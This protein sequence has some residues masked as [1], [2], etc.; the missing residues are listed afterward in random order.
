MSPPAPASLP[1]LR[2][3]Q[4]AALD[5]IGEAFAAGHRRVTLTMPC[6]TGK[7]V[8]MAAL[9]TRLSHPQRVVVFVPTVRLLTQTAVALRAAVPD[10]RLHAVCSPLAAEF[11]VTAT[12][13]GV[14]DDDDIPVAAVA[15]ELGV[16]VTTD[17]DELADGL[18]S[19]GGH[20]V[21]ATYAS[22]AVVVAATQVAAAAWDLVICDEAHHTAGVRGKAWALPLDDAILPARR[23]LFATATV[24]VVDPPVDTEDPNAGPVEVLSMNSL[25]DYGLTHSALSLRA[26]ID[27]GYLSD[28]RVAVIAVSETS[29]AALLAERNDISVGESLDIGSAAAQLALLGAADTDRLLRS[30]MVF[31]NRIESSRRWAAQLRAL[32]K[33][34]HRDV[35]VFHVDG[36]S[37]PRHITAALNALADPGDD[38]VVVSNCRLLA[39]GVDI[40][41]LDAVMFAAPRTGAPDIVQIIGR[42]VRPHPGG[43]DRRALIILPVLHRPDDTTSTEDR[44]ARTGYLAAWQVLTV[45]A[46][47]DELFFRSML[48][49]RGEVEGD[50]IPDADARDR[51]RF[52]TS[53]LPANLRDLFILKTVRRTTSG[54]VRLYYHYRRWAARGYGVA[55]RRG[56]HVPDPASRDGRYPLG[57][58]VASLRRATDA[59][60]VPARIL[61]LFDTDPALTGWRTGRASARRRTV[62]EWLDLVH[63]HLTTTGA[64]HINPW[65]TTTDTVT[66]ARVELGQWITKL[67]P[68]TLT[69]PQ[70]HRLTTLLPTQFPR[71]QHQPRADVRPP[72]W[73]TT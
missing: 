2:D 18:T 24:R 15:A 10:A 22:A 11:D 45:L 68:H 62:D 27:A 23:R 47:E 43:S 28:Y 66:G 7:T 26:A 8:V 71:H 49:L 5:R 58:R 29:A 35:R 63:S 16:V 1:R 3:Y 21:I 61:E 67:K 12:Y 72:T 52:D 36:G 38:L 44:V 19:A 56:L 42:A 40:P 6:G 9:L 55:P 59:G 17:A 73:E 34:T 54:W 69:G 41:A 14:P 65:H 51:I 60:R 48:Q 25:S 4:Q 30:V 33:T 31:H 50:G 57:E 70:R 20:L 46:E 13:T 53:G 64:A 37:N 39:E 32:A